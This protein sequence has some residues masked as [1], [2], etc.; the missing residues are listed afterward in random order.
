MKAAIYYEYGPAEVLKVV[1]VPIPQIKS[2]DEV[3]LTFIVDYLPTSL[4]ESIL[5]FSS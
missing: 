5:R 1:D 4:E 2:S 3:S